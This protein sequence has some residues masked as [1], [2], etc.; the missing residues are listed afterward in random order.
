MNPESRMRHFHKSTQMIWNSQGRCHGT[1]L[2][3]YPE[4]KCTPL[5]GFV[6]QRMNHTY[7]IGDALTYMYSTPYCQ[8]MYSA[9]S[10][11]IVLSVHVQCCQY[12]D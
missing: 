4:Y 2:V 3:I 6:E 10:T 9:V 8:Y 12:T 1:H 11:C 7:E 5:I